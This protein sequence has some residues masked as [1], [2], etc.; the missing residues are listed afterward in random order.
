MSAN[1]I[2]IIKKYVILHCFTVDVHME[3]NTTGR[4]EV[5]GLAPDKIDISELEEYITTLSEFGEVEVRE[6]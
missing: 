5:F 6:P 4:H 3:S 1:L 2:F